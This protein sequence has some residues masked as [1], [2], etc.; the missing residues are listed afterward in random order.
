MRCKKKHCPY[1]HGLSVKR[2]G[3]YQSG[4]QRW[5]C[6]TCQR[7]FH[8]KAQHVKQARERIWFERW[9]IEGYSVRQLCQMSGHSP[10][11]LFRIINYW[12]A[13][14]PTV[15]TISLKEYKQVI[16][17]GT[18]LH[19]PTSIVAL[20]D[21]KTNTVIGGRYGISENS[22]RQLIYFFKPL[23]ER[24]LSP[25]S[26]TVD[27]N[28][29]AIRALKQL[30]PDIIIQ[31]CLVHIQRQGLSWCRRYPVRTDAKKLR[32]IFRQVT[33][34]RTK[35]DR[36]KFLVCV[37]KW[38][39]QYGQDIATQPEKGSVLSDIKRARSMLLKA[40]PDMFHYLD[41]PDIVMSTNGL[42]G[43]FSRL[44]GHYRHHRGLKP[45]KR[46]NYFSWYFKLRPR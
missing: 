20:M 36:D 28:P 41:N 16:F 39:E 33:P 23:V 17:D 42:E 43:Y 7:S 37:A 30:W 13:R 35:Q 34:I 10:A 2:N 8:W 21:A 18:F 32:D 26:C 25:V 4:T 11:K 5:F 29:Q 38:E 27:G 19:R 31:R 9:V 40:L 1:C 15:E 24:A 44:K 3:C 14:F 6:C 45:K 22:E 12:L 46:Q